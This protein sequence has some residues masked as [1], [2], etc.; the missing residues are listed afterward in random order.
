M[1]GWVGCDG[2]WVGLDVMGDGSYVHGER[3]LEL[4]KWVTFGGSYFGK[5]KS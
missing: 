2:W 4:G 5:G 1:G 3:W